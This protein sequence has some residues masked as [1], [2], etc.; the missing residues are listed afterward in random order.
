LGTRK[1]V[2]KSIRGLERKT[3]HMYLCPIRKRMTR[4]E[5]QKC[6]SSTQCKAQN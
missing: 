6:T 5:I 4:G 2:F 3:I 1:Y